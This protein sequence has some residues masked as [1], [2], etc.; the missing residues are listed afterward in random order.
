MSRAVR[1]ANPTPDV[2]YFPSLHTY[3]PL[4]GGPPEVVSI[5]DA[6]PEHLP[7]LAFPNWRRRLAWSVKRRIATHQASRITTLSESA[8]ASLVEDLHIDTRRTRVVRCALDP[9]FVPLPDRDEARLALA[10]Y[11]LE[12]T[13]R[14]LLVVGGF[15]PHK[16]H[17]TILQ[18]FA[19]LVARDADPALRLVFV[20][21]SKHDPYYSN[22]TSLGLW[23]R[24]LGLSGR[25]LFAEYVTDE[26]LIRF[27]NASEML[28]FASF[29]E[30]FGL[31]ALEA[32]A[33]GTPVIA[34][35][36]SSFGELLGPAGRY[37]DP[38]SPSELAAQI[39]EVLASPD[40]R[41]G[42][43]R[44]GLSRAQGWTWERSAHE[45]LA[46]LREAAHG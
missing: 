35:R 29:D 43:V 45:L 33:C 3:F 2:F 20:G 6:I 17:R 22:R 16:N 42:M 1:A 8:R 28:I 19:L 34:S 40:L 14:F 7:R 46:V 32:M 31:P 4:I 30:G 9:G 27:Y 37:F 13:D 15:A 26:D 12:A 11:G 25:V 10:R 44:A 38:H 41:D 39:G 21:D 18:A 24:Q 5:P 36:I 23:V